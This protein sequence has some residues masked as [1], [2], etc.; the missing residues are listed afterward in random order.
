MPQSFINPIGNMCPAEGRR[1]TDSGSNGGGVNRNCY[2]SMPIT[3]VISPNV[4]QPQTTVICNQSQQPMTTQRPQQFTR[5]MTCINPDPATVY[6]NQQPQLTE[7]V[8]QQQQQNNCPDRM[9]W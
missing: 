1:R 7:D 2:P 3:C 4:D 6:H 9:K 5:N 8:G